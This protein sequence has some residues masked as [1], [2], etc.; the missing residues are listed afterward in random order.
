MKRLFTKIIVFLTVLYIITFLYITFFPM[1]YN[2]INHIRWY[3][4]KQ[5][6]DNRIKIE[7]SKILFL[8]DSRLETNVDVKKIPNAW[9]FATGG[10]SPIEMYYCLANYRANY[11][12]PDTVFISFS[13][14]TFIQAYSFWGYA[15]RNNYFRDVEF[16]EI[17]D[18]LQ[19]FPSDTVL[20]NS[21]YLNYLIYK[22]NFIKYHQGDLYENHIFM[23]KKE[24]EQAIANFQSQKGAWIYPGLKEEC[25]ELNYETNLKSFE[26]S[27]LLNLYFMMILDLCKKE[28]IQV[29]FDFMPM[30]ESSFQ[31]LNQ[32]FISGYKR[33]INEI[34]TKF[35][36][37]TFT[38]TV[39]CYPDR[40][41]GDASHLNSK[42]KEIFTE[43]VVAKYFNSD[44]FSKKQD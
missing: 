17:C 10:S 37:F 30:N 13:P 43:Y 18:N 35:P 5:V 34:S 15:I 11:S 31:K 42:G 26:P 29:I 12:N 16:R 21:P 9:T 19:Q 14:R 23:A 6:L 4:F 7:K 24:N 44:I 40:Y 22:L 32:N 3:Y 1:Y 28:N 20:G 41:F 33:Y 27:S 38:D 8:G 36:E 39:Y 25:S 2:S